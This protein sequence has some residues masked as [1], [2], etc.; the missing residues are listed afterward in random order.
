MAHLM[1]Q[2]SPSSEASRR[3]AEAR[4]AQKAK[5]K[6]IKIGLAVGAVIFA[7][8]VGPPFFRWFSNALDDAG[9]TGTTVEEP[10]PVEPAQP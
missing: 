7:V 9:K 1:P 4:A 10:A 3:A 6:K 8:V 5:S 2:K